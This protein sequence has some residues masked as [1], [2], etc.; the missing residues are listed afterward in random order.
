MK[1]SLETTCHSIYRNR[2]NIDTSM[3]TDEF[4]QVISKTTEQT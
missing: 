4:G 3:L 2:N 1:L